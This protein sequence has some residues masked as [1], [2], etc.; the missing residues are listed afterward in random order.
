MTVFI[1]TFVRVV[2]SGILP[3]LNHA[4]SSIR[5]GH[6]HRKRN[7]DHI[8]LHLPH[9]AKIHWLQFDRV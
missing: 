8:E 9:S 6:D 3:E 1:V 4:P 5:N 7:H 2:H